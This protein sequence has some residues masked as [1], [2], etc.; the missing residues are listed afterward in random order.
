M[1]AADR[2]KRNCDVVLKLAEVKEKEGLLHK[3]ISKPKLN[4]KAFTMMCSQF[5]IILNAGVPVARTVQLIADKTTDKHLKK[6]LVS[7]TEDVKGGRTL[8]ASFAEHGEGLLPETFVETISAGEESGNVDKS[9]ES[10]Y[11]HYDKQ[12]KMRGK[13]KQ[14]LTYPVFVILIAIVVVIVLMVKVVPTFTNIFEEYGGELPLITRML[15]SM[16]YFFQKAA[17]PILVIF[18]LAFII[19]KLYSNTESGRLKMARF[20]LKLPVLGNISRLNAASQFANTLTM[21]L[22][23]GLPLTKAVLI[24]SRVLDN[25]YMSKETG[26]LT[27]SLE[28]GLTLGGSMREADYMPDILVDMIA[29]GE[30]TGELEK[31]LKTISAYYDAELE[32]AIQNALNKMDPT[33]LVI[34]AAIAGFIVVAVYVAMFNMYSIM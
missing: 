25:Y 17:L 22:S 20:Q 5:S 31:T 23:A 28:Q 24:T 11:R 6:L 32:M 19:L 18:M 33:I 26:K 10:M 2:I 4:R 21:M 8:S 12:V 15:I 14:A 16:S 1:D 13:V 29:V 34:L 9:F 3:D 30:D 27:A 7:V